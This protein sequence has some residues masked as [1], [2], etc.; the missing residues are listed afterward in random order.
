MSTVTKPCLRCG[1]DP[2]TGKRAFVPFKPAP[3][4]AQEETDWADKLGELRGFVCTEC[5]YI[6]GVI[7]LQDPEG[8]ERRS[9]EF[10]VDRELR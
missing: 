10:R 1:T 5:G 3:N 2:A 9:A 7:D 6:I 4:G 8:R